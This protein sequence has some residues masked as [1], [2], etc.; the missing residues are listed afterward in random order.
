MGSLHKNILLML[1]FLKAPF[2]V[3]HFFYLFVTFLMMLSV[4]L[5]VIYADDSTLI[6]IKGLICCNN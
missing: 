4:V 5:L 6:V 3:L 1:E 2:L